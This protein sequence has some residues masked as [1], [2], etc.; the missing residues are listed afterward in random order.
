M[1]IAWD[2]ALRPG[3]LQAAAVVIYFS[4]KQVNDVP[5]AMAACRRAL[6]PDGLFLAAM[7]GGST[8]HEL[9]VS[10]Q[11]AEIERCF[12]LGREDRTR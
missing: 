11:L 6:K 10:C 4:G 12:Q 7:L 9:R 5:G 2:D 1:A 8:G 3:E